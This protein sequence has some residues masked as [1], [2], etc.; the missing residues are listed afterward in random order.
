[1]PRIDYADETKIS[2]EAL[3]LIESA[4]ETGAPDPRCV[5]I[6]VKHEDAG[7]EWV[8]YWNIQMTN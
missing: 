8:K 5:R 3:A 1:M 4:E 6:Y 7:V 2:P